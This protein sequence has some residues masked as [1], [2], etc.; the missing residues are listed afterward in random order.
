[1]IPKPIA[2]AADYSARLLTGLTRVMKLRLVCPLPV[3]ISAL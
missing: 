1:M 2:G 3:D